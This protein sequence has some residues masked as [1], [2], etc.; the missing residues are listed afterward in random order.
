M[1]VCPVCEHQQDFGVECDV[2]GK[3]LGGLDRLG[4]PPVALERVEGLEVTV[5]ERLGEVAV[6]RMG[7][8]EVS[9][10]APVQVAIELTPDLQASRM[11]DVGE[12]AVERVADLTVDRAPD[13]GQRTVLPEG[14]VTCRYCRNV[15]ASG[16]MCE[17]CGMRLPQIGAAPDVVGGRLLD[18][19]EVKVRC[20]ACG[21]PATA[22]KKCTDCGHD[23]PFPDA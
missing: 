11:A 6:E 8:L 2:C 9:R 16:V 21:A 19:E 12:V 23:V 15:Q 13:D 3:A 10:Y 20:R 4:P 5:P 1:I 7:E 17:R 22:G 18:A 14:P